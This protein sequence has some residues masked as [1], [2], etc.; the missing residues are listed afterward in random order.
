MLPATDNGN[1]FL[2]RYTYPVA[3]SPRTFLG[4]I[5]E[6]QITAGVVPDGWRVGRI[7]SIDNHPQINN[8]TASTN[9]VSFQWSGAAVNDFWVQWVPQLGNVWQTIATLPS[10]SNENS[11]VDTNPARF[12]GASGFYRVLSQ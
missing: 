7:P 10:G 5:D 9:G 3:E 8:V 1:L 11:F 2:G 6:V 4:L 12:N